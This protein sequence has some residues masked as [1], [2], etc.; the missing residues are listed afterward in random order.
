MH[1]WVEGLTEGWNGWMDG[2]DGWLPR[3]PGLFSSTASCHA[4]SRISRKKTESHQA[5]PQCST[6][7]RASHQP[8]L[9]RC[10]P[11]SLRTTHQPVLPTC[12]FMT[13]TP[14]YPAESP[15]PTAGPPRPWRGQG[16]AG[17]PHLGRFSHRGAWSRRL[18]HSPDSRQSVNASS[19]G[20][21]WRHIPRSPPEAGHQGPAR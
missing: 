20:I 17:S 19:Q 3:S 12:A 21:Q 2:M 18:R 16:D 5:S 11:E 15:R 13:K 10:S 7:R 6:S 14:S 9:L 4:P 8:Q 1:G